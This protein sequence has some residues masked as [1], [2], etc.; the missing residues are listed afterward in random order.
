MTDHEVT[1]QRVGAKKAVSFE[2]SSSDDQSVLPSPASPASVVDQCLSGDYIRPLRHY[3]LHPS[4]K[5]MRPVPSMNTLNRLERQTIV[6]WRKPM[7]TVYYFFRELICLSLDYGCRLWAFKSQLFLA[8]LSCFCFYVVCHTPGQ[9][10][11]VV[12]YLEKRLLWCAYWIGLGILSSVGLGT[13]L[14]T[15][16]LYLGPH[17]A[18]VTIAAFECGSLKFPEPPYPD[19]IVCPYN[20][21]ASLISSN[22]S[23]QL[24]D[25]AFK[26]MHNSSMLAAS[27][28][29][30]IWAIMNKVRLESFMWGTGT[31]LGELPPYFMAR[32][33]RLSGEEPDDEDYR[34]FVQFL[35][36][37]QLDHRE[38]W[39]DKL[40]LMIQRVVE[41]VGFLGILLCASI[42]NPLF[43]LAGITCGHFLVPFWT[44][45]GSTLIGKAVIKMH[46]QKLFV[47]IAFSEQHYAKLL[48][49]LKKTPK[50]GHRLEAPFSEYLRTQ[51]VRLH[52]LNSG[53]AQMKSN[54]LQLVFDV[55]LYGMVAYFLISLVNSLAQ[56]YHRRLWLQKKH[57]DR[58]IKFR[59]VLLA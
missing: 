17:I 44:F 38:S 1:F 20:G 32:A 50:I 2:L 7:Q 24:D 15:F 33:A 36:Q 52:H 41:R 47:I 57:D 18:S 53:D 10:Q 30:S 23:I 58:I 55:V 21:E 6:L 48:N 12:A 43:D 16:L 54:R 51:K 4:G 9:H 26:V 56:S 34:E 3:Y 27:S 40:K 42:P 59:F 19:E 49:L 13:G 14:H 28:V 39:M 11:R 35:R 29:V 5:G 8:I 25:S 31:A 46:I 37:S 45:F 22:S